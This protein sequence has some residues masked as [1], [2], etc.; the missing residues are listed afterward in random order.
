MKNAQISSQL[1]HD[2]LSNVPAVS[3]FHHLGTSMT[4]H[5][6]IIESKNLEFRFEMFN[7][8]NHSIFALPDRF[9]DDGPGAAGVITSTVVP[10]RQLQFALK[11]HF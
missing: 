11:L 1:P 7:A 9:I 8:F 6:R 5:L 10:Q 4:K 2:R 3:I